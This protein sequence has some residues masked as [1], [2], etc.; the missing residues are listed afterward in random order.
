M[1][2]RNQHEAAEVVQERPREEEIVESDTEEEEILED[3]DAAP[4]RIRIPGAWDR[5]GPPAAAI[6][7]P[8]DPSIWLSMVN[9]KP[10]HLA[11]LEVESMKFILDY[12]RYS[13]K[14][15]RE[16]LR[17]MQQF[18][19][20]EKPDVIYDGDGREYEEIV[21]LGTENSLRSCYVYTR[22]IP[23]E[24]GDLWSKMRRWRN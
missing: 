19:L 3:P 4:L 16:L 7:A 22:T 5:G 11:D 6:P 21:D 20:E 12:K 23:A 1:A 15:P 9:A 2:R 24:N 18:I 10:S 14:C 13:Q 8:I 17:K